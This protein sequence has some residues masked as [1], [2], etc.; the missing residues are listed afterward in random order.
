MPVTTA[1]DSESSFASESSANSESY[2][3]ATGAS[4][5]ST[6]VSI[7]SEFIPVTWLFSLP[8]NLGSACS[9]ASGKACFMLPTDTDSESASA[10]TCVSFPTTNS[11]SRTKRLAAKVCDSENDTS[12]NGAARSA[13][14]TA[15]PFSERVLNSDKAC[16]N[17]P[18]LRLDS[19]FA[20]ESSCDS[21]KCAS[22]A[23]GAFFNDADSESAVIPRTACFNLPNDSKYESAASSAKARLNLPDSERARAR[24]LAAEIDANDSE[25][26]T[27]AAASDSVSWHW[28]GL[29]A[30]LHAYTDSESSTDNSETSDVE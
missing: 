1:T 18:T 13:A 16:F 4:T 15:A 6:D 3:T 11:E 17:Y 19:E 29:A 7:D 26:W 8:T 14:D 20:T 28:R 2:T 22:A 10:T 23:D 5:S 27:S 30:K 12:Q 24:R 21:E 25:C 9:P